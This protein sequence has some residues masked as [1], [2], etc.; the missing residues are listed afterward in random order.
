MFS[1]IA[2]GNVPRSYSQE[3]FLYMRGETS[4]QS[5]CLEKCVFVNRLVCTSEVF[6]TLLFLFCFV[7]G[8]QMFD[9]QLVL[10]QA[11]QNVWT[12]PLGDKKVGWKCGP[13]EKRVSI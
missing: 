1:V 8:Y 11:L 13:F 6:T 3:Y 4:G 5:F 9:V 7:S 2:Y 12:Q 10:R